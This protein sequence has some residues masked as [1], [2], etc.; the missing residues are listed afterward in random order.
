M[1]SC[2]KYL[3]LS[4][5]NIV[6]IRP[7]FND[8]SSYYSNSYSYGYIV[9]SDSVKFDKWNINVTEYLSKNMHKIDIFEKEQNPERVMKLFENRKISKYVSIKVARLREFGYIQ[10]DKGQVILY[11]ITKGQTFIDLC[12][13][14]VY[15]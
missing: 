5:G 6:S 2:S 8:S 4:S 10:N 9:G 11:G 3:P 12:N 13:N 15:H 1:F 14:R 7:V